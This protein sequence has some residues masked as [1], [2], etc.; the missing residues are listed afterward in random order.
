LNFST[1]AET[2][3]PPIPAYLNSKIH[4][5]CCIDVWCVV[6]TGSTTP[7]MSYFNQANCHHMASSVQTARVWFNGFRLKKYYIP[8]WCCCWRKMSSINMEL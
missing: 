2:S 7:V 8:V 3:L 5:K 6:G 1:A 4:D